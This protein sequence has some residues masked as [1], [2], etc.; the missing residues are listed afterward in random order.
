GGYPQSADWHA[1]PAQQAQQHDPQQYDPQQYDPQQYDPQQYETQQYDPQH[2]GHGAQDDRYGAGDPQHYAD[3]PHGSADQYASY[4]ND[5]PYPQ[6]GQHQA[7]YA[8]RGYQPGE[9]A[10]P[11]DQQAYHPDQ[12]PYYQDQAEQTD[13]DAQDFAQQGAYASA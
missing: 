2:Y 1:D 4:P 5:Y 9:P 6:A 13:A 8:E 11:R 7:G 10:Y 12:H 3:N